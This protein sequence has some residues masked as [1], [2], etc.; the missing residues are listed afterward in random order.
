MTVT[1]ILGGGGSAAVAWNVGVLLGLADESVEFAPDR[2]VGTSAGAIVAAQIAEAPSLSSIYE[3]AQSPSPQRPVRV[4]YPTLMAQLVKLGADASDAQQARRRIGAFALQ[5]DTMTEAARRTEVLALVGRTHWPA[6]L[7]LVVTA[8][9]AYSGE[10]VTFTRDSGVDFVDAVA[11][12]CAVPGVWPPVTI[13]ER[14]YIDGAVRSPTNASLAADSDRVLVLAPLPPA[15]GVERELR[16]LAPTAASMIIA[17]DE[18]SVAAFGE[19][20]LDPD[21]GRASAEAGRCQGRAAAEGIRRLRQAD[22]PATGEPT[23]HQTS[24]TARTQCEP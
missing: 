20:P 11:A 23:H 15:G 5:T 3:S 2:V 24:A 10:F 14:R 7:N 13:G 19:N 6:K 18:Q 17:A 16:S 4:D 12:S 8:V 9:D 22:R 1:L 21:T